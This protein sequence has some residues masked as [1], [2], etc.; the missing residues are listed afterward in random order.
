MR[1]AVSLVGQRFARWTVLSR[2][3][4]TA[5]GQPRWL[6]QCDCGNQKAVTRTVLVDGRSTSCGCFKRESNIARSTKHGHATN[7]ITPTYHSWVGMVS[8]CTN[9]GHRNYARYGGAGIK[10]C[11]RWM[12]FANFLADM[13][14]KPSGMSID[15]FPNQRGNYEPGNCRWATATEQA[16]NKTNNRMLTFMGRTMPLAEWAEKIGVKRTALADRVAN[17]WSDEEALRTPFGSQSANIRSRTLTHN[18]KTQSVAQWARELDLPY[19]R[20]HKR[21]LRGA[22]AEQALRS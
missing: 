8:R 22:S 7:G 2:A 14:E 12:T 21:L 15:R 3:E 16:R 5:S 18:G 11:A 17:G 10:V 9:P 20:I 6:C 13:G 1:T 19:Y 4:N